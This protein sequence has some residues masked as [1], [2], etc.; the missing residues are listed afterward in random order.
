[1]SLLAILYKNVVIVRTFATHHE[2]PIGC[3]YEWHSF[4]FNSEFFLA[5][6]GTLVSS[7]Y[8]K[9]PQDV[10]EIDVKETPSLRNHDIVI[11]SIS[12]S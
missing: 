10:S 2:S 8:L 1:M 9:V 7:A 3:E 12:Y 5:E 11:V 4:S 6:S